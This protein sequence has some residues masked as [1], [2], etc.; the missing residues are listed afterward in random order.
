MG[1]G[2]GACKV[3]AAAGTSSERGIRPDRT[4]KRKSS[5]EPLP[6]PE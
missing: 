5:I 2:W 1:Y 3:E 6:A 4:P